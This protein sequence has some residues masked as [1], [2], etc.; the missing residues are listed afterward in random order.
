M[1]VDL[2]KADLEAI[3]DALSDCLIYENGS[4]EVAQCAA[5][6]KVRDALGRTP[7]VTVEAIRAWV[8]RARA[9]HNATGNKRLKLS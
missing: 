1:R 2:T 3:E 9:E 6:A 4:D 8:D 5:L 7:Q